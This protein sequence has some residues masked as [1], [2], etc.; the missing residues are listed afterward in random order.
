MTSKLELRK[1]DLIAERYSIIDEKRGGMGRVFF[2]KD[3]Q[4]ETQ[5]ICVLKTLLDNFIFDLEARKRFENEAS[6]WLGLGDLNY[7]YVLSLRG[8]VTHDG[9]P[10]LKMDYCKNGSLS[11][12]ISESPLTITDF[13]KF[14]TQLLL[15][16]EFIDGYN[17]L[18]H[19]DLKPANILFNNEGDVRGGLRVVQCR[20][21]RIFLKSQTRHPHSSPFPPV[22]SPAFF[23]FPARKFRR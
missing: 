13:I 21:L 10:F 1:N 9:L 14:S 17:K 2:C 7:T 15:G 22:F 8:V 19:R 20:V 5:E 3:I 18:V 11:D 6:V 4:S 12:R 23:P 16:M